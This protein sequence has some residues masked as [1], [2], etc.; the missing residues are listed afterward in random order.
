MQVWKMNQK[1]NYDKS[2]KSLPKGDECRVEFGKVW[3]PA[4]ILDKHG[5]RSY[6]IQTEDGAI[7]RRNRR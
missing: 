2:A 4:L 3:K 6:K 5:K 1:E 7:Y